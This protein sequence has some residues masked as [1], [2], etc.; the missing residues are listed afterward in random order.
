MFAPPPL[1]RGQ[2]SG[3]LRR[4]LRAWEATDRGEMDHTGLP[5]QHIHTEE[6][7]GGHVS[8][9]SRDHAITGSGLLQDRR[10]RS[11]PSHA[12]SGRQADADIHS[13][14]DR[15]GRSPTRFGDLSARAT[16]KGPAARQIS[17]SELRA[18]LA[19][20]AAR[21]GQSYSSPR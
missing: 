19:Q 17:R 14:L 11:F 20:L 8:E 12:E 21:H 4:E 2:G 3:R 15:E 18:E 16:S 5:R 7:K 10:T 9:Y 1:N 6:S 13:R